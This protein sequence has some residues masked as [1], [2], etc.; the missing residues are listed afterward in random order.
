[1][2]FFQI[3]NSRNSIYIGA[4]SSRERV[5]E[6][7]QQQRGV[8]RVSQT[9]EGSSPKFRV[10]AITLILLQQGDQE[11]RSARS[12]PPSPLSSCSANS[13]QQ[14]DQEYKGE[15]GRARHRRCPPT[16]P[17]RCSKSGFRAPFTWYP[18]PC[19]LF[20]RVAHGFFFF[21]FFFSLVFEDGDFSIRNFHIWCSD[22]NS[23]KIVAE[24]MAEYDASQFCPRS[25]KCV[26]S[27][28]S[29][30]AQAV[31]A[32]YSLPR[33]TKVEQ[34]LAIVDHFFEPPNLKS[35]KTQ[36][37][38]SDIDDKFNTLMERAQK[39]I[40][41]KLHNHNRSLSKSP[42]TFWNVSQPP[43]KQPLLP[44][45][46]TRLQNSLLRRWWRSQGESGWTL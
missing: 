4:R 33:K 41:N 12:G 26:L 3:F 34:H 18:S 36:K 14:G 44:V 6:E 42:T 29:K 5:R 43:N 23:L 13:L 40:E 19:P 31:C 9:P 32:F 37:A 11:I 30:Q 38:Q 2:C 1:M 17:T 15:G 28:D 22:V 20:R 46:T 10:Q 16:A 8:E 27:L 39:Q 24:A 35:D 7:R 21:F 45:M 25:L